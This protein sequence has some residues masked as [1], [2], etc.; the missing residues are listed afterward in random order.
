MEISFQAI[1]GHEEQKARLSRMMSEKRLPHA[2]LFYGPQGV[3]KLGV[4][5]ALAAA[6]LCL[7]EGER[8]CGHCASCLKLKEDAHPDYF[9]LHPEGNKLKTIRI[10]QIRAM[11]TETARLP[12]LSARRVIVI[13]DA[14]QMNEAAANSLLK[15]L[16]E[17][18][19][20]VQF[21]LV[22]SARSAL[23]PT[24]LS[25]TS[26]IGFGGIP[27]P[28]LGAALARRGIPEKDAAELAA[29]ADGSFGYAL[30][31]L[32]HGG[33]ALCDEALSF[34]AERRQMTAK[35]VFALA[36]KMGDMPRETLTEYFRY[37]NLL[38]RDFLVLAEDGASTLLYRQD[39]RTRLV[40]LLP[41]YPQPR[42]FSLL[43]LVRETQKR[44]LTNVNA[45]LLL[46][47][48]FL[49]SMMV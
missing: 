31:L 3:G 13:D 10:D 35:N 22:T 4:A 7:G 48:F 47:A 20:A 37:L 23:L 24:I 2:L 9:E 29:L 12:L 41:D 42:V 49:R 6:L 32:E 44:L 11:Q 18:V 43:A 40:A 38:L 15:T 21:V 28:E 45:R 39:L 1:I 17:P 19:G 46:E 26:G 34:L 36:E 25:R 8:P 30:A 14:E 16:E 33:L 5:R 27:L